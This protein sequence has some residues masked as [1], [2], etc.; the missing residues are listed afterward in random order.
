MTSCIGKAKPVTSCGVIVTDGERLLL[1]H[2]TGSPRWDIPK[3]LQNPGET[4]L[5]TALRELEEETGLSA[6]ADLL[7]PLGEHAYLPGKSLVLFLWRMPT[8]PAP[9]SLVCRSTFP[10]RG[11]PVPEF[12]RFACPPWAEAWPLLGKS[13]RA[14]LMRLAAAAPWSSG[15]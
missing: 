10:L 5:A 6:A 14:V 2:A 9:E 7:Q 12:D 11:R 1:G 4:P 8:M 15:P 13:M 3:G